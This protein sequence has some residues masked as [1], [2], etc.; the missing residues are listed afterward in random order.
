MMSKVSALRLEKK[1][2]PEINSLSSEIKKKKKNP[3]SDIKF[4]NFYDKNPS[5]EIKVRGLR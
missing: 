3:S 5:T 4:R 2:D 1:E